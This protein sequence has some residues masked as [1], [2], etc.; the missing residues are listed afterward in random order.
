LANLLTK[1]KYKSANSVIAQF[2]TYGGKS[3]LALKVQYEKDQNKK[4]EIGM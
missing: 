4:R 2:K 1:K 3:I